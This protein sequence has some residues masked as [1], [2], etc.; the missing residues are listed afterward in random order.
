MEMTDN[1]R[2][3]AET[4]RACLTGATEKWTMAQLLEGKRAI[5]ES[6]STI[7]SSQSTR[8]SRKPSRMASCAGSKS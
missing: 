3:L 7:A 2:R 5:E 1:Q 6:T 4:F 8:S